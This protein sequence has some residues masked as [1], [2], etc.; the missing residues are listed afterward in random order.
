MAS[1]PPAWFD[2]RVSP[3][4]AE[5]LA[6]RLEA[7]LERPVD[8]VLTRNRSR[9]VTWRT[10]RAGTLR[11][12]LDEVFID[13][14]PHELETVADLV[15]ER[16]G[17][18]ARMRRVVDRRRGD[19]V[20][21][22]RQHAPP[23][24]AEGR[25]HD[26]T[27]IRDELLAGLF[28]ELEPPA[29]GWSGRA[30]RAR[31]R[32]RLGSWDPRSGAVRIHRR[33]DAED[34]PRFFVASVVHHELCHAAIGDPPI[35]AGRRRLHGPEFRRLERRFPDHERAWDWE[36]EHRSLLFGSGRRSE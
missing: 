4:A 12:R 25:V 16:P 18:R 26:L 28:P 1:E 11:L 29:I 2:G 24:D 34:V 32:I 9:L 20:R 17:A 33:L 22:M 5:R 6:A 13:L 10:D 36:R 27:G 8:V 31:R 30:G 35:V 15:R 23:L 14:E 19:L 21:R 3:P 7:E